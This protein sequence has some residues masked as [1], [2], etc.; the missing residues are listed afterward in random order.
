MNHVINNKPM[1]L[2]LYYDYIGPNPFQSPPLM[3]FKKIYK[4]MKNY[5]DQKKDN[6]YNTAENSKFFKIEELSSPTSTTVNIHRESTQRNKS[7]DSVP[8]GPLL[9]LP[10]PLKIPTEKELLIFRQAEVFNEIIENDSLMSRRDSEENA[11]LVNLQEY[12]EANLNMDGKF[13][14]E[15]SKE[16]SGESSDVSNNTRF[17]NINPNIDEKT[18][19]NNRDEFG[20]PLVNLPLLDDPILSLTH[21]E[22]AQLKGIKNAKINQV[23]RTQYA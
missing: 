17:S 18:L 19:I 20:Q 3:S 14:D 7:L 23:Y 10:P 4:E 16:T 22:Y 12:L 5:D 8:E 13:N 11:I 6:L 1:K 21:L 15:S 2:S 9:P